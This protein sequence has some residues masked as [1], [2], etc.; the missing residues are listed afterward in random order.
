[1]EL[2]L[3]DSFNDYTGSAKRRVGPPKPIRNSFA[4]FGEIG[5]MHR[6]LLTFPDITF[7]LHGNLTN[8][9]C[10][11]VWNGEQVFE[12]TVLYIGRIYCKYSQWMRQVDRGNL[13]R[14]MLDIVEAAIVCDNFVFICYP[15]YIH[16]WS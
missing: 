7:E 15:G 8:H 3:A 13:S 12:K 14:E 4:L 1:M 11:Q 10:S 5:G 6:R 9:A 16:P 2:V